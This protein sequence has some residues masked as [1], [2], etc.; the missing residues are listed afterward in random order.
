MHNF[1]VR[2][3]V[4]VEC[5]LLNLGQRATPRFQVVN[6]VWMCGLN[7]QLGGGDIMLQNWTWH[8]MRCCLMWD[9]RCCN[10]WGLLMIG[11]QHKQDGN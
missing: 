10:R 3:M 5:N 9:G 1:S 2:T 8:R 11:E 4:D 7:M 6:V